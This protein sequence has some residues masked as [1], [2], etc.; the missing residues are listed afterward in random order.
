MVALKRTAQI[1]WTAPGGGGGGTLRD[2]VTGLKT[3]VTAR[4]RTNVS[5]LKTIGANGVPSGWSLSGSILSATANGASLTDY[6]LDNLLIHTNGKSNLTLLQNEFRMTT[7]AGGGYTMVFVDP[8]GDN[9]EI[10]Y[11][12]FIGTGGFSNESAQ[13]W[14]S[15]TGSGASATCATN[16]H[17]HRNRFENMMADTFKAAGGGLVCEW[18]FFDYPAQVDRDIVVYNGTPASYLLGDVVRFSSGGADYVATANRNNP[19]LAPTIGGNAQWDWP[20]SHTDH[21]NTWANIGAGTISRYNYFEGKQDLVAAPRFATINND[22]RIQRNDG[23]GDD[24]DFGPFHSE[25]DFSNR[26]WTGA[27]NPMSIE[28]HSS[29]YRGPITFANGWVGRRFDGSIAEGT[30]ARIT[31]WVNMRDAITDAAVTVPT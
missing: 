27:A 6:Q 21:I 5:T 11:N 8:A 25:S 13:V 19:T 24:V 1:R 12:N 20:P 2:Q 31:S 28:S 30:K 26:G 7:A 9:I 14:Q 15:W 16:L 10:G 22:M 3:G 17:V 4:G 18:N 23:T 29:N